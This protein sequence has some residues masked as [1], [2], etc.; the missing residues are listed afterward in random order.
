MTQNAPG[1]YNPSSFPQNNLFLPLI[2]NG[3]N[4]DAVFD[5]TQN[6]RP[7]F[8]SYPSPPYYGYNQNQYSPPQNNPYPQQ[9]NTNGIISIT[10]NG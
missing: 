8:N 4:N 1:Q 7:Q 9:Q 3:P 10:Q 2:Q 6:S 5:L